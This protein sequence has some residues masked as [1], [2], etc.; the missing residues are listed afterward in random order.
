MNENPLAVK[1]P[2]LELKK[3]YHAGKRLFRF[4]QRIRKIL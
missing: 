1:L 3:S 2:G 4:W